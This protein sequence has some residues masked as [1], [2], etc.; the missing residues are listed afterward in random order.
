MKFVNSMQ[1]RVIPHLF[2]FVVTWVAP[3]VWAGADDDFQLPVQ[4]DGTLSFFVDVYQFEGA[5]NATAVEVYYSIDLNQ[6]VT[7]PADTSKK[8]DLII[9]FVLI[10]P[11]NDT[12]ASF[13][14]NKSISLANARSEGLYAFVDGQRFEA[15]LDAV[16]LLL[17]V[18]E[19]VSSRAGTVEKFFRVRRF[20][21]GLSISDPI[22]SAQVQKSGGN[23]TFEKSG[24]MIVPAVARTFF[25]RENEQ[26]LFAYF[27]IN[28]L[29]FTEGLDSFYR[30]EYQITNL[31]GEALINESRP[32]LQNR[33]ANSARVE[34][35][36]LTDFKSG[37]YKLILHVTDLTT[38]SVSAAERYFSFDSE[39]ETDDLLLPMTAADEKKYLDQIKYIASEAEK[40]LFR[41][42]SPRGKQ[43]F[44]LEFWRSRDSDIETSENE[45]MIEYFRRFAFCEKE[46][47]GGINSD[48]GRIYI[49]YGPPIEVVR[50]FSKLEF[51]KP[52][53]V[54]T[55]ALD[56]KVEF[57]FVD[58]RRDGKYGLVHST[59]KDEFNNPNWQQEAQ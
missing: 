49:T 34:A 36:P 47:A 30:L 14:D 45:F 18:E 48:M 59:H 11:A 32:H 31:K 6:F 56:G 5:Q 50:E 26:R 40:K 46:F 17:T 52:V 23:K 58:R 38:N 20:T 39:K 8:V 24:L 42:L 3:V 22:L 33:G 16:T 35:I 29:S 19:K 51:T 53:E 37:I 25:D 2:F 54:W 21:D 41:Q 55:Y 12:V 4:S 7:Q 15:S 27:E 13:R 43:Q 28:H 57:V 1:N 44:L 10:S 9:H